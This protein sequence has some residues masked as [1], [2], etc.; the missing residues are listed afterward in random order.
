MTHNLPIIAG[1]GQVPRMM[2][3]SLTDL[4]ALNLIRTCVW[5]DI[6]TLRSTSSD[7][8]VLS[9]GQPA[10]TQ[11]LQQALGL[12]QGG[13]VELHIINYLNDEDSHV[14]GGQA[15]QVRLELRDLNAQLE[16]TQNN[17]LFTTVSAPFTGELPAFDGY[18]NLMVAPEDS[19]SPASAATIYDEKDTTSAGTNYWTWA[20]TS[21]ANLA[22]LWSGFTESPT[23]R[24]QANTGVRLVRAYAHR[25]SGGEF[26]R[27][28]KAEIFDVDPTPIPVVFDNKSPVNVYRETNRGEL[29]AQATTQFIT[30][31]AANAFF[32][33]EQE[34]RVRAIK[35]QT[36]SEAIG[37][38][39]GS[40]MKNIVVHPRNVFTTAKESAQLVID[41]SV[42]RALYGT[43]SRVTVGRVVHDTDAHSATTSRQDEDAARI[44][45][46]LS[47]VWQHYT[48]MA[49]SLIDAQPYRVSGSEK[50]YTHEGP[51]D[52]SLRREARVVAH[53]E[54]VIPGPSHY[55]GAAGSTGAG[56]RGRNAHFAPYDVRAVDEY[57]QALSQQG[58]RRDT[59]DEKLRFDQWRRS[60]DASFANRVG[61]ELRHL[62]QQQTQR[63]EHFQAELQRLVDKQRNESAPHTLYSVMRW[64]GWVLFWSLAVFAGLWGFGNTREE[65]WQWVLNLNEAE[66]NTK[67]WL[68]GVWF[69]LWLITYLVQTAVETRESMRVAKQRFEDKAELDAA[70]ANVAAARAALDRIDVGYQQFLSASEMYG[71]LLEKPFGTIS[72]SH[73]EAV[74]PSNELPAAVSFSSIEPDPQVV[75][76]I[77]QTYRSTLYQEG[78]LQRSISDALQQATHQIAQDPN[79]RITIELGDIF[80]GLGRGSH[81]HLD[82][83]SRHV[84]SSEFMA[85]DR[86]QEQ[87]EKVVASI[88]NDPDKQTMLHPDQQLHYAG[89]FRRDILT[90]SDTSKQLY[91]IAEHY[92]VEGTQV[93]GNDL[94]GSSVTIH[95]GN[96]GGQASDFAFARPERESAT[97]QQPESQSR[98]HDIFGE[99]F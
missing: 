21:L 63:L 81:G 34:A 48:G 69:V 73:S 68:F 12:A 80:A 23:N 49:R 51:V 90:E 64:L 33:H 38:F 26:Q 96:S 52:N 93:D 5:I 61:A 79:R 97:Q 58:N 44:A 84:A 89:Y 60:Y 36:A 6:D 66:A 35:N 25:V 62:R 39:F 4:A 42:Q 2:R 78:W 45:R 57:E 50:E 20:A 40:W 9:P 99:G 43:D 47:P 95:A 86:S 31:H 88:A 22:G 3:Q 70:A 28:L 29:A 87:W 59:I 54:D 11:R 17:L 13:R 56:S 77:A 71:A 14:D 83:L 94:G 85:Q 67:W 76:S 8:V 55:F 91:D 10:R 18:R 98:V 16:P 53:P 92:T 72:H 27:D 19:A 32:S 15:N 82:V 65:P 74:Q 24:L 41:D 75:R 7:V 46:S 30:N 37:S 1:R